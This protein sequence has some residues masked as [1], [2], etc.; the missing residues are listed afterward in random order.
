MKVDQMEPTIIDFEHDESSPVAMSKS[1]G[2]MDFVSSIRMVIECAKQ[3][4]RTTDNDMRMFSWDE[5]ERN[6]RDLIIDPLIQDALDC[7]HPT[8]RALRLL[9]AQLSN[10]FHIQGL[11]MLE[12]LTRRTAEQGL[13]RSNGFPTSE[14][15]MLLNI[16]DRVIRTSQ[17]AQETE[18][19]QGPCRTQPRN[20]SATVQD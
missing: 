14:V 17:P 10:V 16:A 11:H 7:S 15:K 3:D 20:I 6:L 19:Q 8:D 2:E 4:R 18:Y 9:N 1:R 13:D 12:R 5:Y